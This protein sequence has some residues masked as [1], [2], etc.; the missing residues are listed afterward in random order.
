MINSR[1]LDDLDPEAREVATAHIAACH[2]EGIEI[3]ITSTYRDYESQ[4]QLYAIGRNGD[5]RK[6]VT[7]APAG[8]SW[9]N[10]KCAWDVVPVI[11]GKAV[12]DATDPMWK[13][14]VELGKSV[15]AE[16]GA[17]WMSFPDLPHFQVRPANLQ[18][19]DARTR[20]DA[21]GTIFT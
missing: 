14:V 3:I 11:S 2:G 10:F 8:H 18:L 17:E 12:W 15:G 9:H 21:T 13:R 20:F 6:V 4:N 5:T 1:S 16:A 7:N 19:A